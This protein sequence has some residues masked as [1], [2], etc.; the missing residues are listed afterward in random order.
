MSVRKEEYVSEDFRDLLPTPAPA[1]R[2][3][4][5]QFHPEESALLVLDMQQFFL[6]PGSHAFVPAGPTLVPTIAGLMA[7]YQDADRPI[8][9]TQHLNT[10]ANAGL[11]GK[12]WRDQIRPQDPLAPIIPELD[13]STGTVIVKSQYDAFYQTELQTLLQDQKIQQL[14]ICGVMTNLCCETTARSAF[15]RGFE[16]FFL[17]DGTATYNADLHRASLQNLAFGFA[18][19]T[20]I[21]QTTRMM[22]AHFAY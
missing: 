8:I 14:V 17:V 18:M 7:A 1:D 10:D 19:L 13:T 21:D 9:F 11:M 12:W 6:D 3:P 16:V 2:P 22:E 15:I 20:T 5:F 4:R